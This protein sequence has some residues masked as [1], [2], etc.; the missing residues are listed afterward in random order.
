MMCCK[1]QM[2]TVI[3]QSLAKPRQPDPTVSCRS[4]NGRLLMTAV[5]GRDISTEFI[6][7]IPIHPQWGSLAVKHEQIRLIANFHGKQR[8]MAYAACIGG[9]I[10]CGLGIKASQVQAQDHPPANLFRK[11]EYAIQIGPA[12]FGT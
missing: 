2:C 9:F 10:G 4:S 1:R 8:L 11:G 3:T 5:D 7:K 12:K 6:L